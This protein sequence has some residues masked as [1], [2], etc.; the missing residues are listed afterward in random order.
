MDPRNATP[1]TKVRAPRTVAPA[2]RPT[3]ALRRACALAFVVLS[4]AGC[5]DS[6]PP[7]SAAGSRRPAA[8][9]AT[10]QGRLQAAVEP[11]LAARLAGGGARAL[12]ERGGRSWPLPALGPGAAV[13]CRVVPLRAPLDAARLS[14]D[15]A[16]PL[17]AAGARVL[18]REPL[19]RGAW[20]LDI[21]APGRPTHTL[22]LVPPDLA[23]AVRWT[24]GADGAAPPDAAAWRDL[25]AA[26]GPAIALIIDDWGQSLGAPQRTLLDLP[27]PLTLAVLPGLP[28]SREVA[29]LATPLVLPPVASARTSGGRD[30]AALRRDAGCPVELSLGPAPAAGPLRREI[31]VHLPMQPVD[32]PATDPGPGALLVGMGR[33]EVRQAVDHAL[34]AVPGARG[35]NNHMGS[36]AT[37]DRPLMDLLMAELHERGLRFVDSLTTPRSVAYRAAREAGVPALRNR[38]FLDVDHQDEAA[39]TAALATLVAAAREGGRAVGIAHPHPATAAVLAREL[40]RY[41]AAGVRFVTVSELLALAEAG[42]PPTAARAPSGEVAD[43]R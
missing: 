6:G 22:A 38:L 8:P 43:A 26:P 12:A 11:V 23:G 35:L 18:W 28:H 4:I 37:A 7:A 34:A 32:Y 39:I 15:L 16:A 19:G 29:A 2:R 24:A 21:G 42:A 41:A 30:L 14:D 13:R 17:A 40:P 1:T 31:L 9:P 10:A 27:L 20:R 3:P 36:A 25:A 5:R 33:D